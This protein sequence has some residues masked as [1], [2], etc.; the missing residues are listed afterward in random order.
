MLRGPSRLLADPSRDRDSVGYLLLHTFPGRA[1]VAGA[2]VRF[3]AWI[4]QRIAGSVPFVDAIGTVGTL[5]LLFGISYFAWRL[6]KLAR[7]RLLWRVRRKLILSYIFVGLVPAL[8]IIVFFALCGMLLFSSVSS[9]VVRTRLEGLRDQAQFAAGST[10]M[11]LSRARTPD[12]IQRRLDR[13]L[14]SL[15]PRFPGVSIAAVP[16]QRACASDLPAPVE[17][18]VLRGPAVAGA[19]SHVVPPPTLPQWIGCTGFSQLMAYWVGS[20][21]ALAALSA[22]LSARAG[23]SAQLEETAGRT[24]LFVRAVALPD[25]PAP[26]FAVVIDVPLGPDIARRVRDETGISLRQITL[27]GR[28]SGAMPMLG[29]SRTAAPAD[30]PR[31][32]QQLGFQPSWVVFLDYTDWLTGRTGGAAMSIDMSIGDIYD[33]LAP[34]PVGRLDLTFGQL[35]IVFIVVVGLLFLIIQFVALVMGLALARSI[36]GSVHE[37]FV[38]T[39]RVRQGDFS[40]QIQVLAKDQLGDLA[41]SFNSMTSTLGQLLVEM[42]EKKRLEEELRIAREIQMS[43]LPQNPPLDLP[44]VSITAFCHPAREVGGDYYDFVPLGA[45]RLG[46]L[47]ADVSG[48]GTSAALYMAELKGLILSL[49]QIHR[50]PR[51]LLIAANGII[52]ANLDSRSFITMTYAILNLDDGTLTWARAGHTPLIQLPG[53]AGNRRAKILVPDGLVLGLKIDNGERFAALL[54]EVTI[55]LTQGDLFMFF[56]DGLSEQMNPG[57]E[58]F[59]EARLGA[60]IEQHRDLPFDELR[61]RIMRE[62][63][64]FAAGAAQHDDMTFILLRIDEL[65][66][67]RLQVDQAPEPVTVP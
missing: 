55:P 21:D 43:L 28:E 2:L 41:D 36:T 6:I 27:V 59:G 67:R 51:E 60:I 8:L 7:R 22:S 33:R 53:G 63:R 61:E 50:S 14:A 46:L 58:L 10:A 25:G 48:K 23:R 29:R 38:G 37:L 35:L 31:D 13:R 56:T 18:T 24:H 62:V 65:P 39:E 32:T 19:W 12:D 1:L 16:V 54:E 26:R 20:P 52:S 47:I 17:G 5:A 34:S 40:H 66:V 3:F 57:D 11:E 45:N 15:E 9:Y 64:A 4:V 30:V 44:G 42:A 49:G